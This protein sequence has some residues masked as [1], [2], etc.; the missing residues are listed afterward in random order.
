MKRKIQL[1]RQDKIVNFVATTIAIFLLVI[2]VYPIYYCFI[3]SISDGKAALGQQVYL[4]PIEP[5]LENYKMVFEDTSLYQAYFI[6]ILRTIV[7][8]FTGTVFTGLIAYP[9]S[10]DDLKYRRIYTIIFIIT[11]YFSG[12]IIPQYLV[13]R[14]YGIVNTFS[15][16]IFPGLLN[17]FNLMLCMNFFR[18]MPSELIE[19]GKIDGA[20][21]YRIFLRI[22]LPLSKPIIA[23]IALFTGVNHWNDWFTSAYFT[24]SKELTTLPAVLM[25]LVSSAEAQNKIN[26]MMATSSGVTMGMANQGPTA[27]SIRYATMLISILPIMLIYPFV[28]KYFDKGIMLG[29]V[30]A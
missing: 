22:I 14:G 27:E 5:T 6:T 8:T 9:L 25:R 23:T 30:K 13:Y 10:R 12:G 3:S 29:A 20:G 16:Y 21:E 4:W 2:S 1:S 24:T 7:G 18:E 19:S 15:V 28:Q 26:A 11:M 17:V